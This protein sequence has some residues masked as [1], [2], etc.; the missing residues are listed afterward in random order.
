MNSGDQVTGCVRGYEDSDSKNSNST[1][2]FI[3]VLIL[4]T[5]KKYMYISY[6]TV[7]ICIVISCKVLK[8]TIY[9]QVKLNF[10]CFLDFQVAV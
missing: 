3:Y 2:K 5:V 1:Y 9:C 4:L 10:F 8:K 7:L 6:N